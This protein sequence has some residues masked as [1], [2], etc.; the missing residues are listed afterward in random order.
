MTLHRDGD[1]ESP[2]PKLRNSMLTALDTLVG[3]IFTAVQVYVM[4]TAL[5]TLVG[6]IVTAVQ[7]YV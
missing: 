6:R 2:S 5:D 7:V 3:R 1:H 4:L